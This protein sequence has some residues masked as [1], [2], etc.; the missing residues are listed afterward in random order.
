M[1]IERLI[2]K[3]KEV[4]SENTF[5]IFVKTI[6]NLIEEEGFKH[7]GSGSFTDA[8]R[9]GRWVVKLC[10][11]RSEKFHKK[12]GDGYLNPIYIS[13][14]RWLA[15]QPKAIAYNDICEEINKLQK[16]KRKMAALKVK[17]GNRIADL[18]VANVGIFNGEVLMIDL[19]NQTDSPYY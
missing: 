16:L 15:V 17:N 4:E 19:N 10:Q 14:N 7:I 6:R 12:Y 9:K 13:K 5:R 1:K 3:F 2:E 11:T 18:R 8:F